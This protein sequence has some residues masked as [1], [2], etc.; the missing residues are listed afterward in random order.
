M[1]GAALILAA[2]GLLAGC[3]VEYPKVRSTIAIGPGAS[4]AKP[5]SGRVVDQQGGPVVGATIGVYDREK[6]LVA[7][8]A[9]DIDGNFAIAGLA[10]GEY[11]LIIDV[12]GFRSAKAERLV[13]AEGSSISLKC[14]LAWSATAVPLGDP[15]SMIDGK[16]TTSGAVITEHYDGRLCVDP[17]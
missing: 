7:G 15:P 10:P 6:K 12:Q 14:T 11:S 9:T 1:S 3:A 16:S 8:G 17:Q 4:G 2:A 13:V 5:I